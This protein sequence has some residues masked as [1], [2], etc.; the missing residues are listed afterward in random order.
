MRLLII[1]IILFAG[2]MFAQSSVEKFTPQL[3]TVIDNSSQNEEFIGLGFLY[4]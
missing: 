1:A 3:N 4:R 2:I